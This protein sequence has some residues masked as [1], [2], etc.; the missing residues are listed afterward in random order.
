[1]LDLA[2]GSHPQLIGLGEV[3]PLLRPGNAKLDEPDR[4][5][6]CG[7]PLETCVFWSAARAELR[8][9][10]DATVPQRY[11]R[12]MEVFAEVFGRDR[13]PVD[14][15]KSLGALRI[16]AAVPALQVEVL[17]LIRD[18]RSW[19]I[20]RLDTDIRRREFTLRALYA[21]HGGGVWRPFL[22][23]NSDARFVVWYRGNRRIQEFVRERNLPAFQ[24][25]YEEFSLDPGKLIGEICRFLGVDPIPAPTELSGSKSHIALG[26]RMRLQSDRQTSISYDSRWF[27][28]TEW[29]LPSLLF[30]RI[31]R[32]NRL[33]VYRNTVALNPEVARP[34]REAR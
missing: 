19:T 16:A 30:P 7:E 13:V 29:V 10:Q 6:S 21:I 24:L 17:H 28:R 32:Y 26:N 25:G 27:Y 20:L 4:V 33:N 9:L 3:V 22:L 34:Q 23:R 15:S 14:S 8:R 1:V 12:L 31:M 5:C 11:R 18:V 2:L